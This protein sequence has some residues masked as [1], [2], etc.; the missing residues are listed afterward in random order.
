VD[1]DDAV[2]AGAVASLP[3]R[4]GFPQTAHVSSSADEAGCTSMAVSSV[5]DSGV[6]I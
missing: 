5:D 1:G 4:I 6:G 3:G 2:D